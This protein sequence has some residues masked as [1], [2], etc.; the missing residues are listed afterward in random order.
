MKNLYALHG[1]LGL[2]AD[3]EFMRQDHF[4][5]HFPN[6]FDG[7]IWNPNRGLEETGAT[8]NIMASNNSGEN[9]LLGYSLGGRIALNALI[10]NPKLWKCAIIVSADP[11]LK[12]Q[13]EKDQRLTQDQVW[14]K[15][16]LND[17]WDNLMKA[18]NSQ[19]VFHN[20]SISRSELD[21]DRKILAAALTGWSLATQEDLSPMIAEVPVPILWIAGN[22]DEKY[23]AIA[24]EI[25]LCHP[26]SKVWIADGASHRV[27]WQLQNQ[28]IQEIKKFIV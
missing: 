15:R 14:K 16:F 13:S 5:C 25:N 27:P 4:Q 18:W 3:W 17:P 22:Q 10:Q 9:I 28:F 23:S 24:K 21:Y 7:K 1:F 20:D 12:L 19:P 6:L 2:S 8:L 11:G 26:L